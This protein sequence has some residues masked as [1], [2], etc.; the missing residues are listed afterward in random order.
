VQDQLVAVGHM[1]QL[2][3]QLQALEHVLVHVG[4]EQLVAVLAPGLGRVHGHIRVAE[5]LVG[6]VGARPAGNHAEAGLDGDGAAVE[7]E[8]L[9]Q[10]VEHPGGDVGR[11]QAALQPPGRGHQQLVPG[12]V[13]EAV[14]DMLEGR[15]GR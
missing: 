3:L 15:R 2:G 14:V 6:L 5:Q 9:V 13:A 1:A 8:R 7:A 12:G 4:P 10:G 11:A